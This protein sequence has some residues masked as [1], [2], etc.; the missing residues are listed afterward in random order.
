MRRLGRFFRIEIRSSLLLLGATLIALAWANSA[1]LGWLLFNV[2]LRATGGGR[3]PGAGEGAAG[4]SPGG[5][6]ST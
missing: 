2:P 3:R 1:M 5:E 6:G 4:H